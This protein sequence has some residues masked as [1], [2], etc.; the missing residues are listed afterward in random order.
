MKKHFLKVTFWLMVFS[1]II[2]VVSIV[3]AGPTDK[4]PA[5]KTRYKNLKV[6]TD[7][8]QVDDMMKD[9]NKSLGV[10]CEYCHVKDNYADDSKKELQQGRIMIRLVGLINKNFYKGEK[11]VTCVSCHRGSPKA[12]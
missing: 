5:E 7:P 3:N 1:M 6:I 8:K 10:K 2:M 12:K 9:F 4:S 11:V